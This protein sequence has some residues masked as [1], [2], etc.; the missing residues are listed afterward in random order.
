MENVHN[1]CS[2]GQT[3]PLASTV[4][5]SQ[6]KS[7]CWEDLWF[8]SYRVQGRR[9]KAAHGPL[10]F[11]WIFNS[12]TVFESVEHLEISIDEFAVAIELLSSLGVVPAEYLDSR[13]KS[14]GERPVQRLLPQK[15]HAGFGGVDPGD[16]QMR[17]WYGA[18]VPFLR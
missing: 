3:T 14:R 17:V 18:G 13:S 6:F 10:Q 5:R 1:A 16:R 15:V 7:S 2:K 8:V 9:R 12:D 11:L 4:N